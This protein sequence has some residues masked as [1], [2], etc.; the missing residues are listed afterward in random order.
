MDDK[1]LILCAEDDKDTCELLSFV[2]GS[3]GYEVVP[4]FTFADA[5]T[6]A[7]DR[8]FDIYLLDNKMP[9]GSGV[10]LCKQIR[11]F[12]TET[13]II[14][15]SADAFPREIEEAMQAGANDYLVKPVDM[16]SVKV[17]IKEVYNKVHPE[18][19][20]DACG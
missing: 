14:F 6:K 3:S 20:N 8:K 18:N 10:E 17:K 2:L 11:E 4:A 16:D 7:L 5:L 12:D 19:Y 1:C 9:D 13:P 15:Y